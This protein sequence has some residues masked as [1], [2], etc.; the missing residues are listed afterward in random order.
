[1]A[2]W[3][4][5]QVVCRCKHTGYLLRLDDD[6]IPAGMWPGE[7]QWVRHEASR[8]SSLP[9]ETEPVCDPLAGTACIGVKVL[10]CVAPEAEA[11]LI[12]IGNGEPSDRPPQRCEH[13]FFVAVLSSEGPLVGEPCCDRPVQCRRG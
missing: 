2:S 12:E 5:G 8:F 4:S 3:P 7:V 1:M 9:I 10:K 6:R 13:T 11:G